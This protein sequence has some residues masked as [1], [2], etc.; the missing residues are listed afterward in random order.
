MIMAEERTAAVGGPMAPAASGTDDYARF[1]ANKAQMDADAGF[2]PVW[3]P[4]F[5]FDFQA[6]LVAWAIRKGRAALFC[7]CGLGKG[8]MALVWAEN[9]RRATG[10][11]VLVLTPLAV[12]YQLER[13]AEKFGIDVAVSRDGSIPGGITVANYERLHVF[14]RSR[15]GAVVC[16]E[17]SCIKAMDGQRRKEVTAFMRHIPYRLLATATAAPNDYIE[18]GTASEALGY[19]GQMDMLARFFVNNSNNSVREQRY[20][21]AKPGT[22]GRVTWRFKGHAEE[23]FWRWVSS[24]ARA[25][26]RPSDLGFTN[27]D[28]RFALPPLYQREHVVTAT[29][30][31]QDM[32]FNLPAVGIQE[33]RDEARR[34]IRERCAL[35]HDLLS[36]DESG[37]AWCQLNA[38]QDELERLFGD[39]AV[40]VHGALS[41]DEKEARLERF[42]RGERPILITKPTV[43]GFGLNLQFCHRMTFFVSHS[44]ESFYQGVRRCW[45]FGQTRPVQVDIITTDGGTRVLESIARKAEQ[46]DTM[47]SALTA[48]MH[49]ALTIERT[50]DYRT[51]MEVAPWLRAS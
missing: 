30:P 18:L 11:P 27:D 3:L 1:L 28:G 44:Y 17:S 10:K 43:A 31:R 35:A 36:G 2:E 39:R 37:I 33:E 50:N 41:T 45:R 5:L 32:L 13:E 21:H 9:M 8:P 51:P 29:V 20:R 23:P 14:D 4:D 24:W 12:A 25:M 6:H 26:R 19:L 49:D 40:S 16:D 42:L 22:F 47:F 15:F 7:D 38:E 46:A 34:T 48:H